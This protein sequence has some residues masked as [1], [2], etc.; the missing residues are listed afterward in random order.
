MRERDLLW[1]ASNLK[2]GFE[3]TL[4]GFDIRRPSLS[5]SLYLT[6]YDESVRYE[7]I[8]EENQNHLS[9]MNLFW[10]DP[11]TI[12]SVTIPPEARLLAF[13]LPKE[14]VACLLWG[15]VSLPTPSPAGKLNDEW[16]LVGFDVVDAKA[17]T[18]GFHGFGVAASKLDDVSVVAG[19]GLN[20]YGLVDST[21]SAVKA[22]IQFDSMFPEHAPFSPCGIWLLHANLVPRNV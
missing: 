7:E 20:V 3:R 5:N 22:A 2:D 16:E 1:D 15:N 6:A 14:Y 13:D 17:Q 12:P 11:S 8:Y 9:G 21:D 19:Y 4:I 18:S 10:Q